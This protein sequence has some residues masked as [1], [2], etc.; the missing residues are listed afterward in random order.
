M[1][2]FVTVFVFFFIVVL[3]SMAAVQSMANPHYYLSVPNNSL[4]SCF[5]LKVSVFKQMDC[6]KAK[7]REVANFGSGRLAAALGTHW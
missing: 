4:L 1:F 3:S 5:M 6:A 2:V 7:K